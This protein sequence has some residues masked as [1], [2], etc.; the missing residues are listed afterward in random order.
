MLAPSIQRLISKG[1]HGRCIC[2][3]D[4]G[5][6]SY[7]SPAGPPPLL[8]HEQL[9]HLCTHGWLLLDLP[10]ELEARLKELSASTGGVFATNV[11]A[12]TSAYPKKQG[13]EYGYYRVEGE[14]EYITL[15]RRVHSDSALETHAEYVWNGSAD[16]LYRILCDISRMGD[17]HNS[18]WDS[19]VTGTLTFPTANTEL[20]DTSP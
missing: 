7:A 18:V 4:N 14:K 2:Y 12:K 15:R 11:A 5:G 13:T 1:G 16:L 20:K 3:M 6:D 8:G 17:S 9:A 10:A 19:L